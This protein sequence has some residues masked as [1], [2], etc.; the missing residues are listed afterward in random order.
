MRSRR[1][2]V[3]VMVIVLAA[4]AGGLLAHF[5]RAGRAASD[6]EKAPDQ[7]ASHIVAM[8][9]EA[10][11]VLGG[12][13]AARAD[14]GTTP[15][16]AG[17][18]AGGAEAG[19]T[20]AAG[21]PGELMAD[22]ARSATIR[23][24]LS[25]RLSSTTWPALDSRVLQG[26]ILGRVSDAAPMVAPRSGTVLRVGAQPGEVV[27]AGQELL[28]LADFRA[29]LARVVWRPEAGSSPP[30]VLVISPLEGG[31]RGATRARAR[32]LGGTAGVDS[33]TRRPVYLYRLAE[34]W[35]GARP[36]EPVVAT[37]PEGET[38]GARNPQSTGE[39]AVV[40]PNAAVVQW[41]GLAWAYVERQP[42][43]YVRAR[44]MTDRP[45]PGGYVVTAATSGL[46]PGDL[47]VTRGAQQLLS[48][49]FRTHVQMSDEA[50]E[51]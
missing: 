27:Q 19:D 1:A 6:Q 43:S 11:I 18:V 2:V 34:T 26:T 38:A 9:D 35:P 48:E 20:P 29:L 16:R 23:A 12:K 17:G 31:V 24:A 32:L 33:L 46:H 3:I 40:V 45:V 5:R 47:V 50:D 8:G 4:V 44:V 13:A 15:L 10:A 21:L 37:I 39:N 49:E 51:K 14:I 41:E 42:N 25:G 7:T 28:V 36:G 30:P 22:P